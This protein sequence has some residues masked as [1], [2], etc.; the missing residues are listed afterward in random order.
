VLALWFEASKNVQYW[1]FIIY[2]WA[3][4]VTPCGSAER[5]LWRVGGVVGKPLLG[6]PL[7]KLGGGLCGLSVLHWGLWQYNMIRYRC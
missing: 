1:W 4:H 7:P 5:G 3:C 2:L 6:Y